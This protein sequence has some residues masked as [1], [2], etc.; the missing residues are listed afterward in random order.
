MTASDGAFGVSMI[1]QPLLQQEV[2][3]DDYTKG[4]SSM[5]PTPC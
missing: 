5:Q 1:G 4:F 2:V 3:S